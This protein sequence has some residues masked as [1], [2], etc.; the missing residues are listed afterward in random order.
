MNNTKHT[1][2]I[3]KRHSQVKHENDHSD[4]FLIE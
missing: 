4:L 3:E 2:N 1:Q